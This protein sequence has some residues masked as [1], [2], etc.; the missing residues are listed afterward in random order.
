MDVEQVLIDQRKLYERLLKAAKKM[1]EWSWEDC[2]PEP[3]RDIAALQLA[4]DDIE[5]LKRIRKKA[6]RREQFRPKSKLTRIEDVTH[7]TLRRSDSE[8]GSFDVPA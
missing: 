1:L 5:Q 2:D 6:E 7:Q 8:L 4:V 3:Q